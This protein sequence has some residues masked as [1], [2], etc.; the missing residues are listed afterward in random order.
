MTNISYLPTD[1]LS[2]DPA[3]PVYWDAEALDETSDNLQL[4][5]SKEGSA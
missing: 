4:V 5:W 3:D 2:Y 1:G